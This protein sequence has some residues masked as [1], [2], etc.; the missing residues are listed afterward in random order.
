MC[1]GNCG[2]KSWHILLSSIFSRL[3]QSHSGEYLARKN[4]KCLLEFDLINSVLSTTVNNA[5]NNDTML[6]ELP[7][8]IPEA[9]TVGTDYHI[10]CFG[11][12]LNLAVKAFLSLFDCSPKALK[13]DDVS[14]DSND[15]CRD[16][17]DE[18]S[19]DDDDMDE[20]EEDE[21]GECDDGDWAEIAELSKSLDEVA[22]LNL[23]DKV[24]GCT[25]MKKVC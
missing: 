4:A 18:G 7:L 2:L 19:V 8:P 5:S 14:V 22:E 13:A 24:I 23:D 9:P 11:H 1:T 3:T 16:S 6:K 12:I 21:A 25:T 17:D 10:R 20:L 15:S